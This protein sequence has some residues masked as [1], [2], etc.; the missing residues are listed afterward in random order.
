[1]EF[2][3]NI[4]NSNDIKAFASLDL[5]LELCVWVKTHYD[6]KYNFFENIPFDNVSTSHLALF[7]FVLSIFD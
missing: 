7:L 3:L 1:M 6:H 2:A 5:G 4:C